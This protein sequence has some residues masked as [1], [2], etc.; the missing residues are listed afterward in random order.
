MKIKRFP[1]RQDDHL[2]RKFY[3]M[4]SG[5]VAAF[6]FLHVFE[7]REAVIIMAALTTLTLTVD[8]L[9]LR[10]HRLNKFVHKMWGGVMRKEETKN[11]SAQSFYIM[12]MLWLAIAFPKPIVVHS[13][14]VLAWMDPIAGFFGLRFGKTRW[15][16]AIPSHVTASSGAATMF[17][18]KTIEGSF[19]GFIAAFLAGIVAWTGRWASVPGMENGGAFWPSPIQVLVL[20]S[21]AAL[22]SV[23]A[24]AWP[25]QWDDNIMIP[26]WTSISLWAAVQ[27]LG[28][29]TIF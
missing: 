23:A 6:L 18:N 21:V 27:V 2:G 1:T 17:R 10:I 20:S 4:M 3:H 22:T 5:T 26:F 11:L 24:E 15:R 29:P 13:L 19:A 28:I 8:I 14:L 9:R 7:R 16:S 12:G 25:S